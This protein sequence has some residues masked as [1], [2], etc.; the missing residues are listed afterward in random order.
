MSRRIE[1]RQG[2]QALRVWRRVHREHIV[3]EVDPF[4][5][6]G[7][8]RACARRQDR[9]DRDIEAG[10]SFSLLTEAQNAADMLAGV[11]FQHVCDARCG[12]WNP[13]ER[14]RDGRH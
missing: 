14:R 9:K 3:T 5:G 11:A 8:W 10:P 6:L 13:H 7:R 12:S 2:A 1:R 4:G